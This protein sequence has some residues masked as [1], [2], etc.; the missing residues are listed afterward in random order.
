MRSPS[1]YGVGNPVIY[2]GEQGRDGFMAQRWRAR[3]LQKARRQKRPN[4]QM[5]DRLWAAGGTWRAVATG[6]VS[7]GIQDMGAAWFDV[8]DLRDGC[9][10]GFGV[11]G[12]E[13]DR[14]S[15]A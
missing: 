10:W 14:G 9:S 7:F 11:D 8:L 4:V 3:S 15:A 2:V 13:P 5:G 12:K 6:A 1:D